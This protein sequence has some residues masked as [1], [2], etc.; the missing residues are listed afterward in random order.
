LPV[1]QHRKWFAG[2][3]LGSR[4]KSI[5]FGDHDIAVDLGKTTSSSMPIRGCHKCPNVE[6]TQ[7]NL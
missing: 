1:A 3:F 6:E 5:D 4:K 2:A 7:H